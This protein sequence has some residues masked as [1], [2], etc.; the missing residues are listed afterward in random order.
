[1]ANLKILKKKILVT[2]C[3]GLLGQKLLQT[4]GHDFEV[5]GVGLQARPRLKTGAFRYA[6]CDIAQRKE[7][8]KLVGAVKP[9]F[10][11]NAAAYT[12]VDGCEDDRETC[13]KANAT[14]PENLAYL[15]Q[16]KGCHI[17][18]FS[19]DYVFDG[20]DGPYTEE[21][22]PNPLGYYAKAKLAGENAVRASD[23]ASTI[24]RT[25][26]LYG[27]GVEVKKNF[28]LW[29][30]EKLS[31][32]ERIRVVDDQFGHPTLADDLAVAL[33]KIVELGRTGLY[34]IVGPTYI[35]R[36]HFALKLAEIFGFDP[37]LIE[38]IK[39]ADLSQKAPRP[40]KSEFDMRKARQELG[41]QMRDV[42]QGLRTLKQQLGF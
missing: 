33:R 24:V 15:A 8:K 7:V 31:R 42:E 37:G 14:G 29:L 12:N 23:A 21:S 40:L 5:W 19:T 35:D 20:E 26:V 41:I 25:M 30:V 38:P 4:F 34:H 13:W 39:T 28:A 36:Y 18:H 11:V 9:H 1:M 16:L 22:K 6:S 32:G 3:N 27:T 2:G 17:I 10:I